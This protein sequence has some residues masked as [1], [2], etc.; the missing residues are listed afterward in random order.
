MINCGL[1]EADNHGLNLAA[2]G[3]AGELGAVH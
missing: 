1:M 2:D 3:H